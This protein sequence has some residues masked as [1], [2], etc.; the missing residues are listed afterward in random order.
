MD[1]PETPTK[2]PLPNARKPNEGTESEFNNV[3]VFALADVN[4]PPELATYTPLP[5]A[6]A[7]QFPAMTWLEMIVGVCA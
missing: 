5:Y 4:V 2:T 7:V 6:T 1:E 3:Q